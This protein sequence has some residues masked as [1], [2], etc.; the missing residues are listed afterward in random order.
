MPAVLTAPRVIRT[1]LL[2]PVPPAP[3]L[4][5]LPLPPAEAGDEEDAAWVPSGWARAA[6]PQCGR[7]RLVLLKDGR[8]A[9]CLGKERWLSR[10]RRPGNRGPGEGNP[11][12][13]CACGCGGR[14]PRYDDEGRPRK[15][16]RGHGRRKGG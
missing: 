10:P 1:R 12:V 9:S 7:H 2:R 14:F 5:S 15:Y 16:I 13:S 4:P 3:P 6:C 11:R 8:C